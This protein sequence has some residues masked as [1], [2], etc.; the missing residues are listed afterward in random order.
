MFL[1]LVFMF[2]T[3]L[4]RLGTGLFLFAG[5]ARFLGVEQFG[6]FSYWTAIAS[7]AMLLTSFGFNLS[8]LREIPQHPERCDE[9]L[10]TALGCKVLL[11][12]PALLL[13]LFVLWLRPSDW[14]HLPAIGAIFCTTLLFVLT[15]TINVA[16]RALGNFKQEARLALV[17]NL[18]NLT[19][20]LTAAYLYRSLLAVAL[21]YLLT[22]LLQAGLTLH[23]FA[24]IRG[25]WFRLHWNLSRQLQ[26]L[27]GNFVYATDAWLASAY[28]QIDVVLLELFVDLRAVGLYQAGSKFYKTL[29][30]LAGAINNVFIPRMASSRSQPIRFRRAWQGYTMAMALYGGV[31]AL[32]LTFLAE[33]LTHWLFGPEYAGLAQL[34]PWFGLI[35]LVRSLAAA[36]GGVLTVLGHQRF[37]VITNSVSLAVLVGSALWLLPLLGVMGLMYSLLAANV[38]ILTIYLFFFLSGRT[39]STVKPPS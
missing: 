3:L 11:M 10:S 4:V 39:V 35:L 31:G 14:P 7:L 12:I 5:V 32:F 26:T 24:S 6:R 30:M 25:H 22:R 21:A 29:L 34:F 15:E 23:N 2:F 27:R 33:Q 8:L 38:A 37:R 36:A 13:F 17:G 16:M 19:V 20:V 9:L 1:N 28:Q 18:F